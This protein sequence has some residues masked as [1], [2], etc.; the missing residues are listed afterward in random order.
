MK[1]IAYF[2]LVLCCLI[3]RAENNADKI[4]NFITKYKNL[5]N[6]ERIKK[7]TMIGDIDPLTKQS[8]NLLEGLPKKIKAILTVFALNNPTDENYIKNAAE[9]DLIA[10]AIYIK[11][12]IT[13]KKGLFSTTTKLTET[14]TAIDAYSKNNIK[15]KERKELITKAKN[16]LEKKTQGLKPKSR[17][18]YVNALINYLN[19]NDKSKGMKTTF[20]ELMET[21]FK[22]LIE[23][24]DPTDTKAIQLAKE[25]DNNLY[26]DIAKTMVST[27]KKLTDYTK[28]VIELNIKKNPALQIAFLQRENVNAPKN[29]EKLEEFFYKKP[30]KNLTIDLQALAKKTA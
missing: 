18:A 4:A 6:E 21:T 12:M 2:I 29:I 30:L 9:N 3:A 1:K 25:K 24:T 14:E 20:R 17:D 10:T 19:F 28:K 13:T 11:K 16:Y 15:T 27:E 26:S 5:K 7:T 8:S 23:N 22:E